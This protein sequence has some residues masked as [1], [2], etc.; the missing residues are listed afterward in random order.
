MPRIQEY[1]QQTDEQAPTPVM[2]SVELYTAGGKTF[3]QTAKEMGQIS[4]EFVNIRDTRQ[5]TKASNDFSIEV[6][7]IKAKADADLN[8]D[9][10]ADYEKALNESMIKHSNSIAAPM[11]RE[12]ALETFRMHGYTAYAD[13]E[14]Q[15]RKRSVEI[16]Q[17][18]LI[19]NVELAKQN[20]INTADPA[21]RELQLASTI[22]L[23]D[24]HFKSGIL[25]AESANAMKKDINKNWSLT[26]AMTDAERDPALAKETF[27]K[28]GYPGLDTVDERTKFVDFVD[29]IEKQKVEEQKLQAKKVVLDNQSS[30]TQE[31]AQGKIKDIPISRMV[32]MIANHEVT[33]EFGNAFIKLKTSP[34]SVDPAEDKTGFPEYARAVFAAGTEEQINTAIELA[35]AGGADGKISQ[36]DMQYLLKFALDRGKKLTEKNPVQ[37]VIDSVWGAFTSFFNNNSPDQMN[38]ATAEFVKEMATQKDA[39]P[40]AVSQKIINQETLRKYPK[41]STFPKEG[42]IIP[43]ANGN[44]RRYFPD[45]H[46]EE[47]Q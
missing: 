31:V 14:Q 10:V 47:V 18:D 29:R 12:K 28:G 39:D 26:E 43:D 3:S 36:P 16:A 7:Q 33:P 6:A 35:F 40:A 34:D 44:K 15:K 2:P 5:L 37:G 17:N 27:K 30:I 8:P 32:E 45:G 46:Y 24:Q 11:V 20:F 9:N 21:K 25:T 19:I 4:Q 23:I 38:K 42:K 41:I 22:A 1:I 13:I